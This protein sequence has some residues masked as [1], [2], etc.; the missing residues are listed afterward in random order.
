MGDDDPPLA[1]RYPRKRTASVL[2]IESGI[3]YVLIGAVAAL[4]LVLGVQLHTEPGKT[5]G[6]AIAVGKNGI[7]I[8]DR[9][10]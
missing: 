6:I 3:L 9:T 1:W 2:G 5:T 4:I 10:N 8:E 7:T